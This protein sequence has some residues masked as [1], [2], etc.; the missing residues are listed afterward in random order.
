MK[1][2]SP[3]NPSP[4]TTQDNDVRAVYDTLLQLRKLSGMRGDRFRNVDCRALSNL[5]VVRRYAHLAG[6]DPADA[7]PR[8]LRY[9]AAKLDA[10]QR[11]IVDAEL[12]LGMLEGTLPDTQADE[13]YAPDLGQRRQALAAHWRTLHEALDAPVVVRLRSGRTLRG[14]LEEE[15]FTRLAQLL[16]TESVV[17]A[18]DVEEATER[19]TV[20]VVGDA[21]WDR[22][23]SVESF[24]EPGDSMWADEDAHP[25][26]KGL[27]RAVALARL[28]LDARLFAAVGDDDLS[29]R[30]MEYLHK[31]GVD[32]SLVRTEQGARTPGAIVIIAQD[33]RHGSIATKQDRIRF[34][35]N[36]IARTIIVRSLRYADAVLLTFEQADEVMAQVSRLISKSTPR[37]WLVVNASPPRPLSDKL[38]SQLGAVD[39]LIGTSYEFAKMGRG[40]SVSDV[41]RDLLDSDVG[42]V[43]VIDGARCAVHTSGTEP[44]EAEISR[45]GTDSPGTASAF[46]SA[47][48]H[49]LVKRPRPDEIGQCRRADQENLEWAAAA[50]SARESATRE[51]TAS[52]PD[53]M[54][55]IEAIDRRVETG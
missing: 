31:N 4:A 26:G 14:A 20:V 3:R 25:G 47:F 33:G 22:I 11:L 45:D 52:I 5:V 44:L 23:Y 38:R 39:Y 30:I 10:A 29:Q 2:S 34:S 19:P 6:T 1:Q 18:A 46:V 9:S 13:L 24:L 43:V 21:A 16:T 12:C 32:T 17:P 41:V 51:S 55:T 36:L 48:I 54:P 53:S 27:G 35:A 15:A 50:V 37:P 49:Q 28:G 40:S 42:A 8:V 7:L